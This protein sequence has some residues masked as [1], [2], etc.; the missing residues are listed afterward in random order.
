MAGRRMTGG[1]AAND[2]MQVTVRSVTPLSDKASGAPPQPAP[3]AA[4][5][6]EPGGVVPELP[7]CIVS[8]KA[9]GEVCRPVKGVR[10]DER[11][12][13]GYTLRATARKLSGSVGRVRHGTEVQVCKPSIVRRAVSTN[14]DPASS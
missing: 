6:T 9:A 5:W 3:D 2:R 13:Y 7:M 8:F 14:G 12:F 11:G 10:F 4:R 1:A